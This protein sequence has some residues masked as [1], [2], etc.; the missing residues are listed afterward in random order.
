L[1]NDL[2]DS[3]KM[4]STE[5]VLKYVNPNFAGMN[6]NTAL[7]IED[8]ED[9]CFLISSILKQQKINSIFVHSIG[10]AKAVLKRETPD[11]I[12]LDNHL[13]DGLGI[14]FIPLL[15]KHYPQSKIIFITAFDSIEDKHT[16]LAKGAHYFIGKPFTRT[17]ISNALNTLQ[18]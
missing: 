14:E 15:K 16:A 12:F 4:V 7:I 8:E 5:K 2:K 3:G 11:V 13:K 17:S 10:Q 1:V 18:G 9:T 6:F